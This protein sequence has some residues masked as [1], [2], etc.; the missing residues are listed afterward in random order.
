[1][2]ISTDRVSQI[3]ALDPTLFSPIQGQS[4]PGDQRAMLALH[5]AARSVYGSFHYLENPA[6]S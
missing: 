3:E 1:M 2:S 6:G 5:A 4:T